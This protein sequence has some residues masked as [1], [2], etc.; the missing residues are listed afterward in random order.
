MDQRPYNIVTASLF[1]IIAVL[2]LLR[3]IFGWPARIGGLD[4]PLWLS[5]VALLVTGA[6]AWFGFRRWR[7]RRRPAPNPVAA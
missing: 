5:W 1:L 2:H 3:I 6:L 7:R 4:I